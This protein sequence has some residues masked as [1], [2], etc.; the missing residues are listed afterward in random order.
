ML[1]GCDESH[2]YSLVWLRQRQANC[3]KGQHQD[4]DPHSHADDAQCLLRLR[5][6]KV[7]ANSQPG[8][9]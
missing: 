1:I 5:A 6:A 2:N 3:S 4:S 7:Q 8:G 9:E